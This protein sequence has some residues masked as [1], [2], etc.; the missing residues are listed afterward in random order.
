MAAVQQWLQSF[1]RGPIGEQML[2]RF[3][4]ATEELQ[5]LTQYQS[6]QNTLV[7]VPVIAI[8]GGFDPTKCSTK[9]VLSEGN[10]VANITG[11]GPAAVLTSATWYGP[12][13]DKS[14]VVEY[15]ILTGGTARYYI[16]G[17]SV[18]GNLPEFT[19]DSDMQNDRTNGGY[20]NDGTG[21]SS[22]Y[23]APGTAPVTG[24]IPLVS[25][26]VVGIM[27]YNQA[28]YFVN[29]VRVSGFPSIRFGGDAILTYPMIARY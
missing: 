5:Y 7:P 4:S 17:H 22:N 8:G 11:E 10:K 15:E 13:D 18:A 23:P 24:G 29:G 3:R 9:I 27:G 21:L 20:R 2:I 26:D 16:G 1:R 25:G 19:P 12:A 6:F 14:S 28:Y